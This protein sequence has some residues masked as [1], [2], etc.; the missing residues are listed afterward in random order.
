MIL[1]LRK[2]A[3]N[4][5]KKQCEQKKTKK[6][7]PKPP[8]LNLIHHQQSE[9]IEGIYP[10]NFQ[11]RMPSATTMQIQRGSANNN[12]THKR[13]SKSTHTHAALLTIAVHLVSLSRPAGRF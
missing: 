13:E 5:K 12:H 1:L 8:Q 10:C 7:Q 3:E 2:A 9:N 11:P 4:E 6:T